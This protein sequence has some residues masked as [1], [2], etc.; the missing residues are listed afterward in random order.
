MRFSPNPKTRWSAAD[1]A[2]S[3]IAAGADG[4]ALRDPARAGLTDAE[5]PVVRTQSALILALTGD[6]ESIEALGDLLYDEVPLVSVSAAKSLAY[7]GGKHPS[8][9]GPA[10]RALFAALSGGD[11][12]LQLRVHPS[13]VQLSRRDYDLDLDQWEQWVKRLP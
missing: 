2:L 5:E 1:C 7:L 11:R 6:T 10:A 13:L 9:A 4:Q 8:A 12:A 3:L